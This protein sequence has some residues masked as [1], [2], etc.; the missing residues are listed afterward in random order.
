MKSVGALLASAALAFA[1][2]VH[3]APA[4]RVDTVDPTLPTQLPRTAIPH[5]YAISVTPHA[6]RLTFDGEVGIDLDVTKPTQAIVLNA[7]ELNLAS[8]TLQP[9]RGGPAVSA[10]ISLDPEAETATLT[11]PRTI[12]PG[13]YHLAIAYSGMI[14][15]QANG[16]FALDY[17]DPAGVR[18]RAIFTQFEPA[19]ARR[20]F[21]G[22]DEPDYKATFDLTARVLADSMAVGNMPAA[23]SKPLPGGLKE[24]RFQTTPTMSSYL[25][26]F[27]DGDFGRI[28]SRAGATETGIVMGRGNESKARTA[29]EAETEILPYYNQYFGT[30]FPLPK[31]DNVAGPGQSQFFSAME[32][33][34]A[35]F[36]FERVLLDDPAVTTERE[37]QAI[38]GTEAHEMA[39]QWF[40]DLVTMGWWSDLWLNEGFASWMATKATKHFHPDWGAEFGAVGAREGA[41][42][43]D[44]LHTTHPIVQDVRTVEQANQA[45]DAITYSKGESVLSMLETYASPLVWQR[46]IQAYIRA[47]EYQNTRTDDLWHAEEAAGAKGLT[48]IAHDFTLQ[49][50]VPLIRVGAVTCDSGRSRV[51]LI[52]DE[53]SA[54][55]KPGSFTPLSWHVPL[56]VA[57]VGGQPVTAVTAGR[58][59]Q[60]TVP[61][62]GPLLVNAGQTG[63]YRSL[64][65]AAAAEQLRADFERI[66]PVDEYGLV[67][68][69]LALSEAGYQPMGIGLD[70]TAAIPTN[71]RPELQSQGLGT[72]TGLY[73]EFEGDPATQ[74]QIAR[75]I[76]QRYTPVFAEIGLTP[77]AGEQPTIAT[78]RPQ[79]IQ[80]LGYVGDPWVNAEALR[81][82]AAL[83]TNPN[84]VPGGLKQTWL[85][86]VAANADAATWDQLHAMAR[87][88]SSA[89][90]RQNL[91]SLLGATKDDALARRALDLALTDEPGKTVSAGII[92]AVAGRHPDLALDFVLAHWAEV[93]KF[94]D[95]S[96]QSRFIGRLASGSHNEAT[97]AR[98]ESYAQANIAASDRKPIDQAIT[99]IRVR[100]ANEPRIT[101][102]ARAWLRSHS[103]SVATAPNPERG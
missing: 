23:S 81:L 67:R 57:V 78:L 50:G 17:K 86:I 39:H 43:Q 76:E 2:P 11:F 72:W 3:S 41:M 99:I 89:T 56:R 48:Q 94:V 49:P 69:Q 59:T 28:T 47:H 26:F 64:Y 102:E 55:R 33:W 29:L 73:R 14:H 77:R 42:G 60:V 34:G 4:Q 90:E 13:A 74:Q 101:S 65:P 6:D 24:V 25:L 44:S 21:P 66:D 45:F 82:F 97:I 1:A 37:R 31:L 15:T 18:K 16:L 62:C 27:G 70:F 58:E 88:A 87:N 53:F 85:G 96:A 95:L 12:A 20:F 103:S 5:H 68:D 80:G 91:Y 93:Q 38:F 7:A 63:Y 75:L 10:Q 32:N 71:A 8:A 9:A 30:P 54:D 19:D 46:G 83:Q 61:G 22:W 100:L 92:G 52:Q 36:T 98:L 35:I 51:S 84:A 79:L 40:G